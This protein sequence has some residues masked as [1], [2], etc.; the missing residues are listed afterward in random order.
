VELGN[1]L[2]DSPRAAGPLL[3]RLKEWGGVRTMFLTHRDDVADQAGFLRRFRC[4]HVLHRDDITS[5]CCPA[6]APRRLAP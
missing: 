4:D 6:T 5:G 2:V 1:V 3:S